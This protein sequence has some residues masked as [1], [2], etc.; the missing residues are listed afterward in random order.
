MAEGRKKEA[1]NKQDISDITLYN[2]NVLYY[3]TDGIPTLFANFVQS[4]G[5]SVTLYIT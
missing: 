4:L 3:F 5:I 1:R 2:D